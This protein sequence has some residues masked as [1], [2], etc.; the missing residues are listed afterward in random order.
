MATN[1]NHPME[2]AIASA[3]EGVRGN[4]GGPFGACIVKGNQIL[5]VAHNTV[6]KD[7]DPT[8]HAEM[9]A[10]R[11]AANKLGTYVLADCVI[12]TTAEPCPM[13]LAAIHWARIDRIYAGLDRTQ[14]AYYGFDDQLIYE[15]IKQEIDKRHIFCEIG[16]LAKESE[17]V[18]KEWKDLGRELY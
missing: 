12:Y 3:L 4:E 15:Q 9:N 11:Q 14:T 17:A 16:L 18:F 7:S 1:H 6:I 5:S 8:C 13:C 10:I 2:L